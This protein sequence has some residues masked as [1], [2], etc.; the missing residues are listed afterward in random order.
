[1]VKEIPGF[2]Y[3]PEKKKYFKIQANHVAPPGCQYSEKAIKERKL[4]EK[5]RKRK[6]EHGRRVATERIRRA[7][8]LM[9]PLI[10]LER[11]LSQRRTSSRD[12][13]EQQ[14]KAYA[15]K[16]QRK[17]LHKYTPWGTSGDNTVTHIL[18]NRSG[19]L[20][21]ALS[22][23]PESA[24]AVCFPESHRHTW[25][26]HQSLERVLYKDEYRVCQGRDS[27]KDWIAAMDSGPAGDS[28]LL[29]RAIPDPVEEETYRW[30]TLASVR[31]PTRVREE[32]TLWSSSPRP[33]GD[34]PFFAI[35]TS[36]GLHTLE[37]VGYRW[38]LEKKQFP[39]D[40][41]S[42]K[43]ASFRYRESSHSDVIA[44]E[45]LTSDV[46]VSGLSDSSIFFH[47]IRSGGTVTRLQHSHA[48]SKIRK[49]DPYRLVVAG[50]KSLQMYD[51]RYPANG[52]Q[53]RP[54][55]GSSRHTS[56][57]P[58]L[59]FPEYSNSA[60]VTFC[61]DIDVSPELGLLAGVTDDRKLQIFS[62][63]DGSV[64]TSPASS[65][66]YDTSISCV[67]FESGEWPVLG[68]HVPRLLVG[69]GQVVE[70]WTW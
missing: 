27:A 66:Q 51:I 5:S 49:V 50:Y 30:P 31:H 14:G 21:T 68:S 70:E 25:T 53:S 34:S 28:F 10:G 62:L 47:D 52:L 16:L 23:G 42:G 12:I 43:P 57:K 32:T 6:R 58:Y 69:T 17:Q 63:L 35:G 39:P 45:W 26:Y 38:Q 9:H 15:S 55:P 48:V 3:D 59:W 67:R 44:V 7:S 56:T 33:T 37:G 4:E 8:S 40:V 11:E 65:Y 64:V 1:M 2:Y 24:V 13:F 29:V 20:I 54:K 41:I 18:R 61:N 60:R 22:R 46:I 19:L 36:Q